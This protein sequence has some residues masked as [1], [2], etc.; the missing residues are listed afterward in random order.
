MF[1]IVSWTAALSGFAVGLVIGAV[2]T[3]GACALRQQAG[4][5]AA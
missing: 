5:T 4:R 1:A 2:G 3:A